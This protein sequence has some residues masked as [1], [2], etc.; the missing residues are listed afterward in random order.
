MRYYNGQ[1]A[2]N[3]PF[4]KSENI[5]LILDIYILYKGGEYNMS[6][7]LVDVICKNCGCEFKIE[8]EIYMKRKSNGRKSFIFTCK[9]CKSKIA[10]INSLKALDKIQSMSSEERM[11][12][13]KKKSEGLKAYHMNM[14]DESKNR[15]SRNLSIGLTRY[16][17]NLSEEQK[18]QRSKNIRNALA[19]MSN[20]DKINK[21]NKTSVNMKRYMAELTKEK[22]EERYSKSSQSHKKYWSS[23]TP[24]EI[25]ERMKPLLDAQTDIGPTE[26]DFHSLLKLNGFIE[27]INYSRRFDSYPYIHPEYYNHFT[28]INP[29][30]KYQTY[31]YKNWDFIIYT[32]EKN[33]LVDIDG[34]IHDPNKTTGSV[35]NKNGVKFNIYEN[36]KYYEMKRVYQIPNNMDAYA[37]LAYDDTIND[38]TPVINIKSNEI[39]LFESFMDIIQWMN[40]SKK[41]KRL[42]INDVLS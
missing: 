32:K 12:L 10:K 4:L 16:Q 34:S 26:Y 13:I 22:K 3:Q 37:V 19:N 23:L 6:I 8:K 29:I 2:A 31:P 17:K 14:S 18:S 20:E 33:I 9:E 36:I 24:E 7:S 15:R 5:V 42:I 1:S 25:Y 27:G 39:I 35:I 30:T 21:A 38:N 41:D 28:D 11:E 40:L